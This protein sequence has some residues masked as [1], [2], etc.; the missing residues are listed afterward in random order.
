MWVKSVVENYIAP[1]ARVLIEVAKILHDVFGIIYKIASVFGEENAYAV[2]AWA[3]TLFAVLG[4]VIGVVR[5][6]VGW[7]GG[8]ITG[9][10]A[11]IGWFAGWQAAA[12]AAAAAAGTGAGP[13]P[14]ASW[15]LSIATI[16]QK[17][18]AFKTWLMGFSLVSSF[19][20]WF[21][22]LVP[23]VTGALSTVGATFAGWFAGLI[24]ILTSIGA[25]IVAVLTSPITLTIAAI[26]VA[27]AGIWYFWDEIVAGV[28]WAGKK[29]SDGFGWALD[30]VER[31]WTDSVEAIGDIVSGLWS[32]VYEGGKAAISG[33]GTWLSET[34]TWLAGGI[35]ALPGIVVDMV[36]SALSAV[37]DAFSGMLDGVVSVFTGAIEAITGVIDGIADKVKAAGTW[38]SDTLGFGGDEAS[39]PAFAGGG[40]VRGPGTGTSDS[41]LARLSNG[42]F[43]FK[44]AAVRKWGVGFLDQL[45]RG[46][47]PAFATGGLVSIPAPVG[48][49]SAASMLGGGGGRPVL[50]Q[51]P[52]GSTT[53]LTGG[54]DAV[55]QLERS[56]RRSRTAS[57]CRKPSHYR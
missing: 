54:A 52:D 13:G 19:A 10:K 33:L 49:S 21:S 38:V 45:N 14:F 8:A 25:G 41:I 27:V 34:A 28:T 39:T 22:G 40:R 51:L 37:T 15:A 24:P 1:M 7:I 46:I 42:E 18:L 17:F 20:S 55:A 3:L 53:S 31:L 4:K 6:L 43:V 48:I 30:K 2:I 29:I 47:M 36:G 50:L 56:L 12:A 44:A 23:A 16:R 32:T 11:V 57:I 9:I 35:A 5:T 26:A